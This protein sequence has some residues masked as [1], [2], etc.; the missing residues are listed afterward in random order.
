MDLHLLQNLQMLNGW[1]IV[2]EGKRNS[3]KKKLSKGKNKKLNVKS[4][5]KKKMYQIQNKIQKKSGQSNTPP[6]Q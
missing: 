5:K 3:T 4:Q 2:Q 1:Q 6:S